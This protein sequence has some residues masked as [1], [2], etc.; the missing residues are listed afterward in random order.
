MMTIKFLSAHNGGRRSGPACGNPRPP[1]SEMS[2]YD[3][4]TDFS[5]LEENVSF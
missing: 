4:I 3:K 5:T 1:R 2:I